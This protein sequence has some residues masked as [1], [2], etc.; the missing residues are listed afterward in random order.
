M[1]ADR[2]SKPSATCHPDR[3]HVARGLCGSCYQ[4]EWKAENPEKWEARKRGKPRAT[5]HPERP[6]LARSLCS[7]CYR[8]EWRTENP[9]ASKAA[10]RAVYHRR[11]AKPEYK[12]LRARQARAARYGLT[13]DELDSLLAA[14]GDKCAICGSIGRLHVDHCHKT[15]AV[16]GLI[17]GGC[18][19]AA[20]HAGDDPARLRAIAD[21]LEKASPL[22]SG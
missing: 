15:G 7:T 9:E 6:A 19:S 17:C 18:N 4:R 14:Q 3:P 20:G 21:Y 5:C 13:L 1:P 12:K 8:R 10:D 11:A 16:R 2:P 22:G